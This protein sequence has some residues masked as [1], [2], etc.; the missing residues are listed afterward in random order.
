LGVCV[1]LRSHACLS[2]PPPSVCAHAAFAP[3]KNIPMK[4]T[5]ARTPAR[6]PTLTQECLAT[7]ALRVRTR[8]SKF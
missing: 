2:V 4:P 3:P 5:D 7:R 6:T 8:G 1:A